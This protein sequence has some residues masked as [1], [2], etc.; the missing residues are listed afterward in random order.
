MYLKSTHLLV[1]FV[2]VVYWCYSLTIALHWERYKIYFILCPPPAYAEGAGCKFVTEVLVKY[3]NWFLYKISENGEVDC[4][5]SCRPKKCHSFHIE[6]SLNANCC[7]FR[8]AFGCCALQKLAK[9]VF[10][11]FY[12]EKTLKMTISTSVWSKQQPNTGQNIQQKLM[13]TIQP[14]LYYYLWGCE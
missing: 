4:Q 12:A 3:V 9:I 8:P 5:P 2:V 13:V 10:F 1:L 14:L 7:I 11:S 6:L